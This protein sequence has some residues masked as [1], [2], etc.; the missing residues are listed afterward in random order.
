MKAPPKAFVTGMG[1]RHGRH[2]RQ[3]CG[4]CAIGCTARQ[5]GSGLQGALDDDIPALHD[6][7]HGIGR[8]GMDVPC[9]VT[10]HDEE[11]SGFARLKGAEL[12]LLAQHLGT[13][14]RGRLDG[15]EDGDAN[16]VDEVV[17]SSMET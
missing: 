4:H 10:F 5:K 1:P 11:I 14:A 12:I 3:R 8:E 17:I 9:D 2:S 6:D 7:L 13:V 15:V 16:L